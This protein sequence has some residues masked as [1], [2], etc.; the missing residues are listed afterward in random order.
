[1]TEAKEGAMTNPAVLTTVSDLKSSSASPEEVTETTD[2]SNE[3]DD[4]GMEGKENSAA[5]SKIDNK[6][7]NA[8]TSKADSETSSSVKP[9]KTNNKASRRR[10]RS[11]GA[12]IVFPPQVLSFDATLTNGQI[13]E[14]PSESENDVVVINGDTQKKTTQEQESSIDDKDQDDSSVEDPKTG[15][16]PHTSAEKTILPNKKQNTQKDS[17]PSKPDD[18][19]SNEMEVEENDNTA[20]DPFQ[21]PDDEALDSPSR[22]T[23]FKLPPE[24]APF[25]NPGVCDYG[26]IRASRLRNRTKKTIG[27]DVPY[28]NIQGQRRCR[29]TKDGKKMI[30]PGN[31]NRCLNCA[32][33]VFKYCHSHR[34]L[35]EVQKEYWEKRKLRD[36]KIGSASSYARE[37]IAKKEPPVKTDTKPVK[38]ES[39]S[40]KSTVHRS[41]ATMQKQCIQVPGNDFE[42]NEPRRCVAL[43][44]GKGRC[45]R[46]MLLTESSGFCY[47]H[48]SLAEK[49]REERSKKYSANYAKNYYRRVGAMNCI[50]VSR[51]GGRCKFRA[52]DDCVFCLT[53]INSP[54]KYVCKKQ[55]DEENAGTVLNAESMGGKNSTTVFRNE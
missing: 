21:K 36:S 44:Q 16:R 15:K 23:Q 32:E 26:V 3:F 31:T 10:K 49:L 54:P 45:F 14:S 29:A 53:H 25:N 30:G 48:T 55:D 9:E 33:G 24:L 34:D 39:K 6:S 19:S 50:A 35:D 28:Q 38:T 41:I 18:A 43:V 1:M 20:N 7:T 8:A 4:E 47:G 11:L 2:N 12:R 46:K 37:N 5:V 40:I 51:S 42:E 13:Q 52:L 22:E 27:N 17:Q